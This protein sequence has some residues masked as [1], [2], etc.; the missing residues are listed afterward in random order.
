MYTT[1]LVHEYLSLSAKRLPHKEALI[2]GEERLTY[3]IID[4]SSQ[5][6]ASTLKNMGM[7]RGDRV[8]IFLDNCAESV[9]SLYGILKAGGIFVTLEGSMKAKKLRYILR[10]SGATILITHTDK[11]HIIRDA[12]DNLKKPCHIVWVGEPSK[13][14]PVLIAQ[15]LSWKEIFQNSSSQSSLQYKTGHTKKCISKAS[16][17]EKSPLSPLCQRGEHFLPLAKGGEEGFYNQCLHTYDH[18]SNNNGHPC[19][20]LDL[21]AL[22]Y[23]SGSTGEP[24]GVMSSH[25]NMIS[26][27]LSITQY[28]GNTTEDIIL[29]VFPLSFDYGLYQVI[30]AFMFGGTVVLEKSFLYPVKILGNIKKESVTGFPIVPTVAALLLRLRDF[31]KY[32]FSS[33]RYITNTAAALPVEH[34][35]KLRSL[36][37]HVRLYSMYGLTECKRV[38]YLPPEELERRAS[39][40]GK[41]MPNCEVF[42]VNERGIEVSPGEI[43]ELVIRGANVMC[44]YWNSPELT[45]KTFRQGRHPGERLLYSGDFF[46]RDEEGFLYFIGRKDDII[47]TRGE[48]VSP[49]EVE[50]VLCEM[51]EITE[52]AVVGVPDEI[53]G[54]AIK[55]FVV[56]APGAHLTGKEI[57]K[58]CATHLESF[59]VP[60]YVEFVKELPTTPNGKI[61]KKVL[62]EKY[63]YT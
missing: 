23:T 40:V 6:I 7:K 8:V 55:A 25:Y 36:L 1:T 38:S 15:S 46:K 2:C 44:G 13:I 21:A 45:A 30:M 14:P 5:Q 10:D 47:K 24:K 16:L 32:D 12:V 33:L 28:L 49:K 60:K 58:Y 63:N 53:L 35:Y 37:P 41:A 52:A 56:F 51:E 29:N 61:D 31:K 59:M 17:I 62:K 4:Q 39:S 57:R 54:Q 22:I 11:A 43:G 19:I 20:N 18:I 3:R 27:A 50:N 26:A 48:R 34:I 9:I 42:I